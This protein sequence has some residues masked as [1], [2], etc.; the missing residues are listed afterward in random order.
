VPTVVRCSLTPLPVTSAWWPLR[1][2]TGSLVA[3]SDDAV[4]RTVLATR[5]VAASAVG[6]SILGDEHGGPVAG[7]ALGPG[8][9]P[10]TYGPESEAIAVFV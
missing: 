4:T 2:D 6:V 9:V 8:L 10:C 3:A 5:R 1:P 7:P